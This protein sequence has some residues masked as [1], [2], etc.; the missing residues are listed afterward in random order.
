[1]KTGSSQSSDEAQIRRRIDDWAKAL[2]AKDREGVMS[3][4]APEVPRLRPRAPASIGA[5]PRENLPDST[6]DA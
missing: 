6:L 2:R 3:H 5:T 4:Y 1:M